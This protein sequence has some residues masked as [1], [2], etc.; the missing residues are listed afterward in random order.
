MTG[1]ILSPF[2]KKPKSLDVPDVDA[3]AKLDSPAR[4]PQFHFRYPMLAPRGGIPGDS[5]LLL[6]VYTV[7]V[8]TAELVVIG[9]CAVNLYKQEDDKVGIL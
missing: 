2:W 9:N 7:D 5:V 3:Y 4:C 8:D 1:R 6:R